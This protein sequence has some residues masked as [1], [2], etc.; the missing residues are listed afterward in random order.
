MKPTKIKVTGVLEVY[1][2]ECKDFE[3]FKLHVSQI[4]FS[5][6]LQHCS[7]NV[8]LIKKKN[9]IVNFKIQTLQMKDVYVQN[10]TNKSRYITNIFYFVSNSTI[11][12]THHLETYHLNVDFWQTKYLSATNFRGMNSDDDLVDLLT[13]IVAKKPAFSK[14]VDFRTI[15]SKFNT[16]WQNLLS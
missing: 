14:Y 4:F 11:R 12:F 7:L 8:K 6:H 15:S 16:F 2:S 13:N 5:F 9:K 3:I 10:S 1:A